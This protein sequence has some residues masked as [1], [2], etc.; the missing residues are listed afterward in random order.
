MEFDIASEWQIRKL[1]SKEYLTVIKSAAL[2]FSFVRKNAL[3]IYE[4]HSPHSCLIDCWA[5]EPR[6]RRS[7]FLVH[8]LS[9]QHFSSLHV[10]SSIKYRLAL[11][12]VVELSTRALLRNNWSFDI[13]SSLSHHKIA[14]LNWRSEWHA[15]SYPSQEYMFLIYRRVYM[16]KPIVSLS[17]KKTSTQSYW[18]S[19]TV[20][21]AD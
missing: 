19:I 8:Q 11:C 3:T 5:G 7:S 13:C 21:A 18:R 4:T 15:F 12:T 17:V 20:Y 9:S 16:R 1:S 14:Y 6:R 10:Q 2:Q